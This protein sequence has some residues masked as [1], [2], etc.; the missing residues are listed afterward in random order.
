MACWCIA[1]VWIIMNLVLMSNELS[2]GAYGVWIFMV[3][4]IWFD[5][6]GLKSLSSLPVRLTF[7]LAYYFIGTIVSWNWLN[8]I[9]RKQTINIY[10]KLCSWGTM[11][12]VIVMF[13]TATR[14]TRG[15][16]AYKYK[17]LQVSPETHCRLAV[18]LW[19]EM[20]QNN[21]DLYKQYV[22]VNVN[23]EVYSLKS[24]WI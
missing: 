3:H 21:N 7:H 24:P 22:N 20:W 10:F 13:R 23:L 16:T 8:H 2:Y 11:Q 18:R 5:I 14:A 9:C 19:L 6:R 15:N 17:M 4:M 1:L 12:P